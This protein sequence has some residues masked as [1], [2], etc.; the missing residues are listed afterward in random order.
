MSPVSTTRIT[1]WYPPE[2]N[3]EFKEAIRTRD[4]YKCAVCKHKFKKLD[5]HHIDY[6]KRTEPENCISLC[7]ACHTRIHE[8]MTWDQRNDVKFYLWI[9]ADE[10]NREVGVRRDHVPQKQEKRLSAAVR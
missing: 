8:E 6:T 3:E 9:L 5:V 4:G 7:R 10:R 2:F 1:P